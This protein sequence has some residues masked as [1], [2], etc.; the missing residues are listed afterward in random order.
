M[1]RYRIVFSGSGGQ[2]LILAGVIFAEA[3]TIYDKKT[4]VQSQSYGPEARG[5]GDEGFCNA[6]GHC[7]V[8]VLRNRAAA[9]RAEAFDHSEHRAEQSYHR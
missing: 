1:E 2:G 6:V 5:G 4:A 7:P 9:E 3:A 8:T